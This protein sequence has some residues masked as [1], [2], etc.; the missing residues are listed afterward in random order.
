[1]SKEYKNINTEANFEDRTGLVVWLRSKRQ[2]KRLMRYGVLHYISNKM[3]YA[4]IYVDAKNAERVTEKL[5]EENFVER[6]EYSQLRDL[7]TSYDN[8]IEK[9]QKEIDTEKKFE[10][11]E[12]ESPLDDNFSLDSLFSNH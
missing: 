10:K 9:M 7:P 1:M 5:T 8:L 3:N 6:V 4:V 2:V 12:D 11:V